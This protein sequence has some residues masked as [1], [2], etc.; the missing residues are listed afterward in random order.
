M[1]KS[2]CAEHILDFSLVINAFNTGN[3]LPE[4]IS[5]TLLGARVVRTLASLL[6]GASAL[7]WQGDLRTATHWHYKQL[8][9]AATT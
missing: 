4:C 9:M 2:R 3:L 6:E 8:T 7:V 5:S 1:Q